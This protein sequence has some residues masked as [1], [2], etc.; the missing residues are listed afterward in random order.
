MESKTQ[1]QQHNQQCKENRLDLLKIV[2]EIRVKLRQGVELPN[3][4]VVATNIST[5]HFTHVKA[6]QNEIETIYVTGCVSVH[7]DVAV[8]NGDVEIKDVRLYNLCNETHGV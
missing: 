2:D 6:R 5:Y 3:G 7:V 4:N 1:T 8:N